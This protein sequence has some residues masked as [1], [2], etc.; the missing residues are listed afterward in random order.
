MGTIVG[1][2]VG[3]I[4]TSL[5]TIVPLMPAPPQVFLRR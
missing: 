1:I 4:V 2:L 3:I 5:W